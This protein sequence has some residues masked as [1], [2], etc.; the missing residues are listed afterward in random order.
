[1][2]RKAGLVRWGWAVMS[3]ATA[4]TLLALFVPSLASG[5]LTTLVG[6]LA[7]P[8]AWRMLAER[9][10]GAPLRDPVVSVA[11]SSALFV[12]LAATR[13]ETA[14]RLGG[15]LVGTI[16]AVFVALVA[17]SWLARRRRDRRRD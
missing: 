8:V 6:A 16:V 13:P 7:V 15:M 12:V 2:R 10:G 1:M 14:E 3:A 17:S 5:Y 9:K 4:T 11:L